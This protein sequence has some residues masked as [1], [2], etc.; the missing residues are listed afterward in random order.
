MFGS[1]CNG[2]NEDIIVFDIYCVCFDDNKLYGGY[3]YC[4]VLQVVDKRNI[5][6]LL[7]LFM[8]QKFVSV[9]YS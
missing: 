5:F 4:Q 3:F 2:S 9:V 7:W 8:M 6:G 1:F